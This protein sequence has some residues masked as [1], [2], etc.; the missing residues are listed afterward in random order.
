VNLFCLKSRA[1]NRVSQDFGTACPRH[2]RRTQCRQDL[3]WSLEPRLLPGEP[4]WW[5]E[6]PR[7]SPGEPAWWQEEPRL[8]PGEP[9]WLP[10]EP[11]WWQGGRWSFGRTDSWQLRSL[12]SISPNITK[13][14]FAVLLTRRQRHRTNPPIVAWAACVL[15]IRPPLADLPSVER[16]LRIVLEVA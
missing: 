6:G 1:N 7:L 2:I 8:S 12:L 3:E 4:R 11:P 5:P 10:G 9:P 16:R 15:Q 14:V 13:I